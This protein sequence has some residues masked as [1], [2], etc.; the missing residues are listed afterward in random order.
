MDHV[1]VLQDTL[2]VEQIVLN[3]DP[4]AQNVIMNLYALYVKM[5]LLIF[6]KEVADVR[7]DFGM[8]GHSVKDVEITVL[9]V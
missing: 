3:V 1:D 2:T 8:M 4:I 6:T 7:T 5:D 9:N